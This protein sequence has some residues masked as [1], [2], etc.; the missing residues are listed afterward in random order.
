MPLIIRWELTSVFTEK[1][2]K[3][4]ARPASSGMPFPQCQ[5]LLSDGEPFAP[6]VEV[7]SL[8]PDTF[9]SAL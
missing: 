1:L 7:V 3:T 2:R 8:D 6:N 9:A 4:G 5:H